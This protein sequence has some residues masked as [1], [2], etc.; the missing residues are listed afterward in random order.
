MTD[1]A[2]YTDNFRREIRER[3]GLDERFVRRFAAGKRIGQSGVIDRWEDLVNPDQEMSSAHVH[4]ALSNVIRGRQTCDLIMRKTGIVSGRSLDVGSAYG[5]MVAAFAERGFAAEGV[6]IDA[7]WCEL[8]NLNCSSKGLGEPI[9]C[10]DF[11]AHEYPRCYDIITCNDVIEHVQEPRRAIAKM[12]SMLEPG[13]ALYLV[14]PNALSWDHV[15][16]DG[17]YGQFGMNLLDHYAAR[18]YYGIRCRNTYQ[19]PYSCGE[20]HPLDWYRDRLAEHGLSPIVHRPAAAKLPT[21]EGLQDIF[22]KLDR[23][24]AAWSDAGL[25]EILRDQIETGFRRYREQLRS[26]HE[27]ETG[28]DPV[29]ATDF[30]ERF[31]DPFWTVIARKQS[32]PAD[33]AVTAEA[34]RKPAIANSRQAP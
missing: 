25:P 23:A 33:D 17:H 29:D 16:R 9:H 30:A 22:G 14:I 6:E 19:K 32:S 1:S 34:D 26:S 20:F 27:R 2:T 10:A 28:K 13:G 15:I 12:A 4:F 7:H 11:L 31:L 24:F 18:E 8:G 21:S 3:F 5:G